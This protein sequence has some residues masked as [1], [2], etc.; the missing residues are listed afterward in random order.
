MDEGRGTEYA[1]NSGTGRCND[2][3]DAGRESAVRG[4]RTG[5]GRPELRGMNVRFRYGGVKRKTRAEK[6]RRRA[7]GGRLGTCS[8]D[9]VVGGQSSSDLRQSDDIHSVGRHRHLGHSADQSA[10]QVQWT[11]LAHKSR[12]RP[13]IATIPHPEYLEVVTSASSPGQQVTKAGPDSLIV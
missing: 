11:W 13:S 7:G 12:Q 2:G 10:E 4:R 9:S 6:G 3:E 5:R 1:M 8:L